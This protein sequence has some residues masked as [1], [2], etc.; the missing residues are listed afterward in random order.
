[1]YLVGDGHGVL[2]GHVCDVKVLKGSVRVGYW[3][4]RKKWCDVEEMNNCQWHF[5]TAYLFSAT[6]LILGYV[7][8]QQL[9][10]EN[11]QLSYSQSERAT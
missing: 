8:R 7:T 11:I 1:M 10:K 5:E 2:A 6:S 4:C 3:V 9:V